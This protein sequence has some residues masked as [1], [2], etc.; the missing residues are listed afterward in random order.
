MIEIY[1]NL[2]KCFKNIYILSI[3]Q[4]GRY[5]PNFHLIRKYQPKYLREYENKLQKNI[6][7]K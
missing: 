5:N 6:D 2:K 4:I 7:K 1:Y 3:S